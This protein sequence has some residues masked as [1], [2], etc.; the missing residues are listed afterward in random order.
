MFL[1]KIKRP[2]LDEQIRDHLAGN[3]IGLKI[4]SQIISNPRFLAGCDMANSVAVNRLGYND[5]G[6]THVRIVAANALQILNIL[7]KKGFVTNF[8][9]EKHGE[10]A[11]AQVIVMLGALLH[12]IGNAIHREHH[13]EHGVCYA[14]RI[15]DEILPEYYSDVKLHRLKLAVLGC[16]Y[17]H[18]ESVLATSLEAGVV[19]VADGTDCENGRARIPYKIFGK[20]DIHAVSALAIKNVLI[21]EGKKKPVKIIIDMS[22]PAGLFQ[23]DEVLGK[24]LKT[25]CID[26]FFEVAPLINGKPFKTTDI[27]ML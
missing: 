14:D 8:V 17:E 20:S 4:Y 13:Q 22:N 19:K 24:K 3:E 25:S 2:P 1:V 12:D 16:V 23:V 6:Y 10:F 15:L 11:D 26:E 7:N 18:D 21:S 27:T 9:K 5:H